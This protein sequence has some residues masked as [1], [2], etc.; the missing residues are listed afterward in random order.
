MEEKIKRL[1][2]WYNTTYLHYPRNHQFDKEI[3]EIQDMT[4]FL[5]VNYKKIPLR[6]RIWHLENNKLSL[7][8]CPIC[9]ESLLSFDKKQYSNRCGKRECIS[10]SQLLMSDEKKKEISEKRKNTN[11]KKYGNTSKLRGSEWNRIRLEASK[12]RFKNSD[13]NYNYSKEELIEWYNKFKNDITYNYYSPQH[14]QILRMTS[15]LDKFYEKVVISQR[16]YHII[17]DNYNLVYCKIC[18]KL[19]R[20]QLNHIRY[21][22]TCSMKCFKKFMKSDEFLK[23]TRVTNKEKY[24]VEYAIQTKNAIKNLR[25][26]V[27]KIEIQVRDLVK[28]SFP[29]I[30][31]NDRSFLFPYEIDLY[32]KESKIGFEINGDYWHVNREIYDRLNYK[33][34]SLSN[35]KMKSFDDRKRSEIS[36]IQKCYEKSINVYHIWEND[37]K[38]HWNLIGNYIINVKKY[39]T[40]ISDIILLLQ[41]NSITNYQI[42]DKFHLL[43][44]SKVEIIIS[45][46]SNSNKNLTN[47]ERQIYIWEDCYKT[48]SYLYNNIILSSINKSNHEKIF[49]RKCIIKEIKSGDNDI[50][51]FINDNH[52]QGYISFSFGYGLYY[53]EKLVEIMTFKMTSKLKNEW[54]IGRLCTDSKYS[55]IGGASKLW[56]H[57]I[58]NIN[59]QKCITYSDVSLFSGN[60]YRNLSGM[61]Y[62]GKTQKGYFYTD[63]KSRYNRRKFQKHKLIKKYP[64]FSHLTEKQIMI[65]K[66][67]YKIITNEG[68]YKFIFTA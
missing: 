66:L 63:G 24:G 68:N 42:I 14:Q 32:D 49:A 48:N 67:G 13:Y 50:I 25:N 19:L 8:K 64:E 43:I 40:I 65:E 35:S 61:I 18:H 29:D 41:K 54:E 62:V 23:T 2:N 21:G 38:K 11:V 6:Q 59:P 33:P 16:M 12:E 1:L 20:F 17:E 51:N 31:F 58:K 26:S 44:D 60:V 9:N 39:N 36:K 53:K 15:F 5:D 57:F 47:I 56:S 34:R 46:F 37:I 55:V 52:V 22:H 27:S 3:Q 10:K 7:C 4:S 28:K 30:I 45:N